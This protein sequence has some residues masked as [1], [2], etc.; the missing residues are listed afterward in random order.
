M[1]KSVISAVVCQR[2]RHAGRLTGSHFCQH[3]KARL[4]N[5]KIMLQS[6]AYQL[7]EFLP[8]YKRELVK[9]LSRNLGEDINNLEVKELFELLFEKPLRTVDDPGRSLLMVIDGL[10]ESEYKG[11]NELLDV[12]ANQFR[13]LPGWVRF[14]FTTR[15]EINIADRLNGQPCST[16]AR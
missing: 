2:M 4:R 3:N 5:P 13:T 16:G 11:R 6:L 8:P 12:M 9:A 7:S 10:D 1:G 14:C 15:P